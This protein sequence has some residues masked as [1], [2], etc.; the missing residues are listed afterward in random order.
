LVAE[1]FILNTNFRLVDC[2]AIID[3]MMETVKDESFGVVPVF[4][5]DD[6]G[7]L[8]CLVQHQGQHYGFPKGH[9]NFGESQEMTAKRELAEETGLIDVNIV[10]KEVFDQAYQFEYEGIIY[11]KTVR[12]FLGF[13][14]STATT[15]PEEFKKEISDMKWLPYKEARK[16]LTYEDTKV[17]L[18][19]AW[20]FLNKDLI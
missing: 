5:K 13:V 19:Q 12:Y 20:D 7:F 18:D 4:K 6:G 11:D 16:V 10:A 3:L 9:A 1:I 8:F 14:L 15:I 2:F 17:I